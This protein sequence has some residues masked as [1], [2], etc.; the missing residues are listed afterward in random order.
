MRENQRRVLLLILAVLVALVAASCSEESSENETIEELPD[1]T[2][3]ELPLSDLDPIIDGAPSNDV[4]PEEGKADA[5]YPAQF[6]VVATQSS[7]KSQGSRG[8]CSIFSTVALM[9][10][11]YIKE[12]TIADPDFSEQFLQWSAKE[13]QRSFRSTGG[14]SA[15]ENLAAINRF[16]IVEEAAWPYETRGWSTSNDER[17]TGD[18]RPTLCYTNGAPP[19]SALDAQRFKLPRGRYINSR[20]RNIKAYMHENKSAV[21]AGMTFFYQSWNHGG[22]KLKINRSYF[23]NGYILYPNEADKTSSLEHRA[24]HSI[25]I[26]GWDDDLEVPMVDENGA[27]IL[28][29]NGEPQMEKG[30]W[31]IKNSWGTGSF[32]NKNPFGSG[33]GW[34][35][36]RYVEEYASVYSAAEPELDFQEVCDDGADNDF[37]GKVDCDDAACVDQEV[38]RPAGLSFEEEVAGTIPDGTGEALTSSITVAQPGVT[39]KVFV[40]VDISHPYSGDITLSLTDPAGTQVILRD[41]EGGSQDDIITEYS[42]DDFAGVSIAGDWTL[43]VADSAGGDAGT[44]NSWAIEFQLSGDVPAEV[45]ADGIDNDGDSLIDCAD[46]DCVE[47]EACV[48]ASTVEL[49]SAEAQIIPDDDAT[50]L[51]IP[52]VVDAAG[53]V[54]AISLSVDISHTFR[55]DLNISLTNPAGAEV[56]LMSEEYREGDAIIRTFDVDDFN[57]LEA[58]GEWTF[59]VADIAGGDEGTL[60]SWN[61]VMEVVPQ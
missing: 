5:V 39:D 17:C 55:A 31:L 59:K 19:E 61:F 58:A 57:G 18:D 44:L 37:N 49:N 9:E 53:L 27:Q 15:R 20:P 35:S 2:Q 34:L 22:S 10:H 28:D 13:E 33:Y 3:L 29:E 36:Y 38:C 60:N 6:D 8:V 30:F 12:G 32:G 50:G 4:L 40:K 54:G 43:T 42:L 56:V 48:G 21:V 24:G 51:V 46:E 26:V 14:S 1:P 45:C 7:V 41:R 23:S 11:L 47:D 52:L 25:L 16:G